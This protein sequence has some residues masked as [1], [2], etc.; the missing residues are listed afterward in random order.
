MINNITGDNDFFLIS[1]AQMLHGAGIFTNIY[2]KIPKITQLCT[3]WGPPVMFV[4]LDSP[5]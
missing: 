4:G 3:M 5:Q 2:P 1:H